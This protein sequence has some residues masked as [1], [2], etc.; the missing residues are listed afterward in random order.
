MC[1]DRFYEAVVR[2]P[3]QKAQTLDPAGDAFS[4]QIDPTVQERAISLRDQCYE[5]VTTALRNLKGDSSGVSESPARQV[6]TKSIIDPASKKKYVS[7]IV[8]L[9]VQSSDRLFHEYIYHTMIE[10][11]L[12]D[13]LLEYGGP[14]L[15]SFLQSAASEPTEE[16]MC[17]FILL[18]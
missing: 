11:C 7:Q 14:Y 17:H 16:A 18:H 12:E 2:L 5:I 15:V 10:L 6:A 4:D 9:A 3:L 8:Q 1:F 13:E